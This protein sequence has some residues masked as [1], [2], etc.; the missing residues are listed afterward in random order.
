MERPDLLDGVIFLFAK[1]GQ[2]YNALQFKKF[3]DKEPVTI[4]GEIKGNPDIFMFHLSKS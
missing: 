2:L 1:D 3:Y 4:R